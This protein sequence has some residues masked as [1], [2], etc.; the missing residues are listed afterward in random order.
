ML[1]H[2]IV[3]FL[4]KKAR[5][6]HGNLCNI[7]SLHK[8]PYADPSVSHAMVIQAKVNRKFR[9]RVATEG[10]FHFVPK[11]LKGQ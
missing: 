6:V 2:P 7:I 9:Y 4:L 5:T 11:S 1:L 8:F 3:L 10:C